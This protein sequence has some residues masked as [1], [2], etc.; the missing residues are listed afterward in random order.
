[1]VYQ[2]KYCNRSPRDH[3]L[4]KSEQERLAQTASF[5][6]YIFCEENRTDGN[7]L[8]VQLPYLKSQPQSKRLCDVNCAKPVMGIYSPFT[9]CSYAPPGR[10]RLRSP[11]S[12]SARAQASIAP[13]K[14]TA[15]PD[16]I[17]NEMPL[18]RR[19]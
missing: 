6:Y 18:H 2:T 5:W 13:S 7:C 8:C 11:I 15:L 10:T 17:G 3:T 19:A 4:S 16:W 9:F 1:M 12:S 14:P